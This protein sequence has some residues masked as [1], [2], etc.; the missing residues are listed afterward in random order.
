MSKNYEAWLGCAG[1][2]MLGAVAIGLLL[3]GG[4][5]LTRSVAEWHQAD[6]TIAMA[7]QQTAQTQIEWSA[8]TEIERIRADVTKKTD[9]TFVLFWIVR[10]ALWGACGIIAV[11]GAALWRM[12]G[13]RE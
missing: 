2:L 13:R 9:V 5:L 7:E 3:M 4:G 1:L 12:G 8:R 6:A 10:A 11:M